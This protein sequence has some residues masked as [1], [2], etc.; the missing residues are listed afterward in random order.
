LRNKKLSVEGAKAYLKN[1]KNK[2]DTQQQLTH[3]LNKFKGF[4]LE[5]KATLA[6][7]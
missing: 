3:T 7:S 5:L 6:E 1:N 2:A 4:L